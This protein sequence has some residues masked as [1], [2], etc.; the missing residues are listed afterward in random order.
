MNHRCP[1][2]AKLPT[3]CGS[4][5][6]PHSSLRADFPSLLGFAPFQVAMVGRF[7]KPFGGYRDDGS[8]MDGCSG[9]VLKKCAET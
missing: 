9:V 6:K 5:A 7:G 4:E 8:H 1:T 2:E 3:H